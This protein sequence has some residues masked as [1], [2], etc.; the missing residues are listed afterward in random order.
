M[1]LKEFPPLDGTALGESDPIDT[2]GQLSR[3]A[4][5]RMSSRE[6]GHGDS[7]LDT[8]SDPRS[9][10]DPGSR[11]DKRSVSSRPESVKSGSAKSEVD[12]PESLVPAEADV[13]ISD[14]EKSATEIG[15]ISGGRVSSSKS[16]SSHQGQDPVGKESIASSLS[17]KRN[18]LDVKVSL[19]VVGV[20]F[21]F[22]FSSLCGVILTLFTRA[23]TTLSA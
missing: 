7:L 5:A 10:T 15:S 19:P 6:S 11:S 16:L 23:F 2:S 20:I 8:R 4:S 12:K 17:L 13:N 18:S 3:S 21:L 22:G 14:A 9:R 1:D